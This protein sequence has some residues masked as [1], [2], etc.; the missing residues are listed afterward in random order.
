MTKNIADV[1]KNLPQEPKYVARIKE[2][3]TA[4]VNAKKAADAQLTELKQHM[5]KVK[6]EWQWSS[7]F[8][9][10]LKINTTAFLSHDTNNIKI[11][12]YKAV[13]N[14]IPSS[15]WSQNLA[16]IRAVNEK[17]RCDKLLQDTKT[18][19]QNLQTACQ[20]LLTTIE[21]K[22]PAK[23]VKKAIEKLM[24]YILEQPKT[25]LSVAYLKA[26]DET[27]L[28]LQGKASTKYY[29][30]TGI[31]PG[32]FWSSKKR[33]PYT[34]RE[35]YDHEIKQLPG[36]P[37]RKMLL[38]GIGIT[39]AGLI[40]ACLIALAVFNPLLWLLGPLFTMAKTI[41]LYACAAVVVGGLA[42]M[43]ASK[44]QTGLARKMQHVSNAVYQDICEQA[45]LAAQTGPT[46]P[47]YGQ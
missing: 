32:I 39:S 46:L 13:Q 24:W 29:H 38:A 15:I 42:M 12:D 34:A 17:R 1:I 9:E 18:Y 21:H 5:K 6:D 16:Y 7:V 2:L 14:N 33:I 27:T 3:E 44:M 25:N 45:R 22:T 41:L 43:L 20:T 36:S 30:Q 35:H 47:P 10:L 31:T 19:Q 4:C 26:L 28:L 11:L 23:P 40:F 8:T 37:S